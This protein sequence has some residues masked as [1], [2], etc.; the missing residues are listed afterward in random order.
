MHD[1][2]IEAI[3]NVDGLMPELLFQPALDPAGLGHVF[4]RLQVGRKNTRLEPSI[5]GE[6]GF[7]RLDEVDPALS[8][9]AFEEG[10][11]L[12]ARSDHRVQVTGRPTE[13]DDRHVQVREP[14]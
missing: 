2:R 9:Q 4:E 8:G 1:L 7:V 14:V 10:H 13:G 3:G 11:R 12:P 5:L 6:A